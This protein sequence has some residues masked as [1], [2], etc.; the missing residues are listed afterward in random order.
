MMHQHLMGEGIPKFYGATTIGERGQ[1]VVP[2]DARKDLNLTH[3][4]KVMVFGAP[5]GEGLLIVKAD[6]VAE[7]LA[8]AN[9][10]LSGVEE[11]LK[12]SKDESQ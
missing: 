12:S 7:I 4:T 11:V 9:K 3:S 10:M 6:S 8:R 1:V 2:V 5:M